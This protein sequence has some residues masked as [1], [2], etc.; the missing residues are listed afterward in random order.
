[1]WIYILGSE[2]Y[3]TKIFETPVHSSLVTLFSYCGH[4]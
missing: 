1:M 2:T 3:I 4:S